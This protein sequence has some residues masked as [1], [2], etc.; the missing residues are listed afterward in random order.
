MFARSGSRA[1]RPVNVVSVWAPGSTS[2]SCVKS[3]VQRLP[4]QSS[5]GTSNACDGTIADDV[6]AYFASHPSALGTPLTPGTVCNAQCWF[7]D[8][9]APG[10]TNLSDAIQWTFCP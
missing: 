3:P 5:G 8:A 4:S 6:L 1:L 7:R 2:Y 9:P 10:T